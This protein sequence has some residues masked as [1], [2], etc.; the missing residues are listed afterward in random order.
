[1]VAGTRTTQQQMRHSGSVCLALIWEQR[2][3]GALQLAGNRSEIVGGAVRF[4][5][6][7]SKALVS[8][9]KC[10]RGS[11]SALIFRGEIIPAP[12]GMCSGE[13]SRN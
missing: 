12:R 6:E 3:T 7:G 9:E 4:L 1:M 13:L 10:N 8:A 11:V 2:F 5:A